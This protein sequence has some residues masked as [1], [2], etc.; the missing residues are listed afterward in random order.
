VNAPVHVDDALFRADVARTSERGRAA[1]ISARS[2]FEQDGV[3]AV[4]RRA[5]S[6]DHP[7]GTRLP[8]CVK[9]YIPSL[10]GPWRMIFQV[11]RLGDGRLGLEYLAAGVAHL[12]HR[13]RARDVYELAHFRLHGRW[14]DR[15]PAGD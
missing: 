4:E 13:A 11:A 7:S 2:R 6:A 8:G 14:P 9:V 12:P 3:S 5:C 10:D 15:R 1:L